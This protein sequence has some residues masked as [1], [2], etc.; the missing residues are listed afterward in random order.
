MVQ[1]LPNNLRSHLTWI[2]IDRSLTKAAACPRQ[3]CRVI[4]WATEVLA[5]ARGLQQYGEP[6]ITKRNWSRKHFAINWSLW[7]DYSLPR[8][9]A[10]SG[11]L[12]FIRLRVCQKGFRTKQWAASAHSHLFSKPQLGLPARLRDRDGVASPLFRRI[13]N[14]QHQILYEGR[15]ASDYSGVFFNRDAQ[16]DAGI[17]FHDWDWSEVKASAAR[18]RGRGLHS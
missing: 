7:D 13:S 8:L 9:L 16:I 5:Q 2:A 1:D 18:L 11:A 4:E 14:K 6:N 12:W 10:I 15:A 17:S 3:W